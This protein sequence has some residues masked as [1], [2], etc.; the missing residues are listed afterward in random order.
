MRGL[1]GVA[2][3]AAVGCGGGGGV[4]RENSG[5]G[6]AP[7]SA[8]AAVDAAPVEIAARPLG[9]ARL[10]D[11]AWRKRA[12]HA[13]FR[14]AR[15][16]EHAEDWAKVVQHCRA[17]L[18]SDPLHLEAAWL[19]AAGIGKLGG[20][21]ERAALVAALQ[22]AEAGDVDKWGAASLELPA[23]Q[24]FLQTPMGEAWRAR[25]EADRAAYAAALARGVLVVADGDV[26]AFDPDGARW[27]RVTRTGGAVIG[28]VA[29]AEPRVIGY[30]TRARTGGAL[31]V[32]AIDVARGHAAHA[33]ALGTAGPLQIAYGAKPAGVW[34]GGKDGKWRVYAD[35][36]LV[37]APKGA[38][39]PSGTWLEVAAKGAAVA[40]HRARARD[41]QADW[42]EQ[43]LASA[44]K[45]GPSSRV[46]SVPS[47]GLIDGATIAW[48]PDRAHVAFVAQIADPCAPAAG[49]AGAAA[50]TSAAF[51]ADA[52]TGNATELERA[53]DGLALEWAGD[54]T[55]AIAGDK[56]VALVDL[57]NT[58]TPLVGATSLLVPR[59]APR[60]ATAPV[61]PG[62]PPASEPEPDDEPDE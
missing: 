8:A 32:G 6:S 59:R 52:A 48:S 3:V 29:F 51:V 5:S 9:L 20:A 17:A 31:A 36:K 38:T 14:A 54:R 25:V 58:R 15:T 11:F 39:R 41:V 45:L 60:C 62:P 33:V 7:I 57:D 43:G 42:D 10:A 13:E 23:L 49:D 50:P 28:V 61:A 1:L 55:L 19:L 37:A 21:A 46:V 56:G 24:P 2:V 53:V 18:K 27:L 40:L 12:G 47:P 4:A 26:F 35:G 34:I 30:V 16:A 22:I 44:V